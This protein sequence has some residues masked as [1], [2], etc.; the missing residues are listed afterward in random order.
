MGFDLG[1]LLRG[2][3]GG[4]SGYEQ[5]KRQRA[6]AERKARLQLL[7]ES[8]LKAQAEHALHPTRRLQSVFT[9]QGLMNF[10]PETGQYTPAQGPQDTTLKKPVTAKAPERP[11]SVA[12][13]GTLLD[14]TTMQPVYHAPEKPKEE[15]PASQPQ[16][17]AAAYGAR[18]AIA[19]QTM[20][21]I[22]QKNFSAAQ[23]AARAINSPAFTKLIPFI[24]ARTADAARAMREFGLSDDAQ[25][26]M[27]SL[28]EFAQNAA[29]GQFS[30]GALRSPQM[31]YQMWS[32]YGVQPGEKPAGA[33]IKHR[34]RLNFVRQGK[35]KAGDKAW[36]DAL[37]EYGLTD[38]AIFGKAAQAPSRRLGDLKAKYKLP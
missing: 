36:K 31:L 5:G 7:Q 30:P 22:E 17:N 12:P 18:A 6:D 3:A 35:L 14:P 19:G 29:P 37:D 1:A 38:D 27:N 10:D 8:L 4:I 9:D 24:G 26:Y 16:L 11:I 23:E 33:E 21:D 25:Q 32:E 20:T 34:N 28:F 2:A 13:G 15:K